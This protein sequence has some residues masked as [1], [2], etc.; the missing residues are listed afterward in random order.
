MP[1]MHEWGYKVMAVPA[2][3]MLVFHIC[4]LLVCLVASISDHPETLWDYIKW[5]RKY[6][7]S[8]ER[9]GPRR[10]YLFNLILATGRQT[11]N[12]E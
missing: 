1:D 3:N 11:L 8:Q 9:T 4:Y 10:M 12:I 7:I 2:G 6:D 5:F